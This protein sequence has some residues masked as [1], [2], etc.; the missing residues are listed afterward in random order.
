MQLP[1]ALVWSL[2]LAGADA[3]LRALRRD[4]GVCSMEIVATVTRTY[5]I[6]TSEEVVLPCKTGSNGPGPI[7][8][9][10]SPS[11]STTSSSSPESP[12]S[13]SNP[14][15][16]DGKENIDSKLPFDSLIPS[17]YFPDVTI[18]EP[19]AI[20]TSPSS[21]AYTYLSSIPSVEDQSSS[22]T[23][24]TAIKPVDPS[25]AEETESSSPEET[26][27]TGPT[28]PEESQVSESPAP[29]E[30]DDSDAT[31]PGEP[32]QTEDPNDAEQPEE[33]EEP[34]VS[35]PSEPEES[36]EPEVSRPSEPEDSDIPTPEPSDDNLST[37]V[38]AAPTPTPTPVEPSEDDPAEVTTTEAASS[39]VVEDDE[40][41]EATTLVE[42]STV[43]EE[44]EPSQYP[45]N[46]PA[47]NV[48]KLQDD[49]MEKLKE[50][51]K[52]NASP[53]CTLE[54]AAVRREW[55]VEP[56]IVAKSD[57]TSNNIFTG[58]TFRFP[59]AR[60]TPRLFNVL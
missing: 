51:L 36:E 60:N 32:E 15:K 8:S 5:T 48:D 3:K 2:L 21:P 42:S 56:F 30:T 13:P 18:E 1:S 53:G 43:V 33:S 38:E 47:D 9:V 29:E 40:P 19:T 49:S 10:D 59:S 12:V 50:H 41:A 4:S 22:T 52:R 27:A 54:N 55:S 23:I 58:A 11:A 25:E 28:T 44:P 7:H 57:A 6:T 14:G 26:D 39:T 34:E 35:R 46:Y 17:D 24:T 31:S 16:G 45:R 20:I 37:P